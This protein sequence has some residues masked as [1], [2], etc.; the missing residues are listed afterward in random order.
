MPRERTG[1]SGKCQSCGAKIRV[2]EIDESVPD[3]VEVSQSGSV[4]WRHESRT[5][6]FEPTE[7]DPDR[8]EQISAHIETHLGPVAN[9]FHELVSDLVHID[10]HVVEPTEDRP[11]YTLVTSGMSEA[12]MNTPEGADD[13]RYAELLVM[14]PADWPLS[15]EAFED[16]QYYWP[17][18]WLKMLARFPH[19]YDTWLGFGHTVPNGDPPE[20]LGPGT[21]FCCNLLLPPLLVP[22]GFQTLEVDEFRSISFFSLIP[23]YRDE[24]E[25]KLKHGLDPLLTLFDECE[26]DDVINLERGSVL[27]ET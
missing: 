27:T 2:P 12:P 10:V 16:E 11:W 7:G 17:I 22:E 21:D 23:I 4:I 18:R 6:P 26:V 5:I 9:V 25:F 1:Q 8:I 3:D 19:E 14:L 24:M 20:P 13:L 15:M